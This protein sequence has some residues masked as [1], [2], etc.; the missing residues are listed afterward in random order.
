MDP[1]EKGGDS[2]PG[3]DVVRS[4]HTTAQHG[5]QFKTHGLFIFRIFGHTGLRVTET[6]E[7]GT[8]RR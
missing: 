5:I 6:A 1:L 2:R 3:W 4:H 7:S 8:N